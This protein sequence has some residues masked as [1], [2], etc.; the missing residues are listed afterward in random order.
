MRKLLL[1]FIPVFLHAQA[2][3]LLHMELGPTVVPNGG[4]STFSMSALNSGYCARFT[5]LSTRDIKS[6]W[7]PWGTITGGGTVS[8]RI[9]T[10]DAT[11]RKPTGTLYDANATVSVTPTTGW[12][13]FVFASVPTTGMV[14][15]TE[16][17][18]LFLTTVAGTTQSLTNAF[19]G[20]SGYPA[21]VLTA[22]DGTTRS[23]F[24]EVSNALPTMT[25]VYADDVE[26]ARQF[27]PRDGTARNMFGTRGYGAKI[28]LTAPILVSGYRI[29]LTRAGT[30]TGD[31]RFRMLDSTDA[32]IA[33]TT[34]SVDKGSLA[35]ITSTEKN[36]V[37]W[38]STPV[39]LAAGTYRLIVDQAD[40]AST[41]GNNYAIQA[42]QWR[43]AALAPA[44]YT[45]TGSANIDATPIVWGND[46][47]SMVPGLFLMLDSIPAA[48]VATGGSYAISH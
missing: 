48:S 20:A 38:L 46:D 18:A 39:T 42:S 29:P 22:A 25:I 31:L 32:V 14:P 23:N 11:T 7:A 5:A 47:L 41:S 33:G 24:A 43:T 17:C 6:I 8:L 40:H 10:I 2:G 13:N 21:I 26:S 37:V 34:R 16:Y 19:G 30:P 9:E 4:A 44:N 36:V 27:A 3:S 28:V 15:Y 1:L 45:F 35:G 12:Q